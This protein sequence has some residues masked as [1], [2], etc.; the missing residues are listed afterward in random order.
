M[1]MRINKTWRLRF[2]LI[3]SGLALGFLAKWIAGHYDPSQE[4][5]LPDQGKTVRQVIKFVPN[6][7]HQPS[8]ILAAAPLGHPWNSS[9]STGD[10]Y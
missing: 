9:S 5:P 6:P 1:I 2:I 8:L 10:E 4:P 7:F 3:T